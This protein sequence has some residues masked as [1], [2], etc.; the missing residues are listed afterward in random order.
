VLRTGPLATVQDLGRPG[1]A[2]VGVSPSGAADR[3]SHRLA[4][5]L[6]GNPEG[7]AT[8]EVTLG[9]LAVVSDRGVWVALTGALV[10]ATVGGRQ[11]ALNGPCYL[12]AHQQL[13][14]GT[15]TAGLRTYLAV[16]GGL[17]V[18]QVLGSRSTDVLGGLGPAPLRAGD[19]L[20]VLPAGVLQPNVDLA[21]VAAPPAVVDARIEPGPRADWLSPEARDLL[22]RVRWAVSADTN[23]VG[24][25][26]E[27][28]RLDRVR[29]DELPPEGVVRGA[30]QVPPDGRPIVFLADHPVTGGYPVVAVVRGADLAALAQARP[31]CTVRLHPDP[32]Y[33]P[34]TVLPED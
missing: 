10:D 19:R 16:R 23:R 31:G 20:P 25:R 1:Y 32:E 9:G 22:T 29:T 21:P 14:L 30:V 18:P 26:L 2:D 34:L 7:A 28:A 8:I 27:G 15:A 6:V 11:V 5:R 17:G 3:A 13:Q 4:N 24:V 12:P 33:A